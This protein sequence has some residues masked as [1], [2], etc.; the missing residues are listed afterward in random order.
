MFLGEFETRRKAPRRRGANARPRMQRWRMADRQSRISDVSS[1]VRPMLV[2]ERGFSPVLP[3]PS[4]PF[5]HLDIKTRVIESGPREK[6]EQRIHFF[7]LGP[8]GPADR[9][10]EWRDEPLDVHDFPVSSVPASSSGRAAVRLRK[11]VL[12]LGPRKQFRGIR[13]RLYHHD[14][15]RTS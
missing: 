14:L 6:H 1:F 9:R 7:P 11:R 12:F 10:P 15:W 5:A 2:A 8:E 13:R 3:P 4:P